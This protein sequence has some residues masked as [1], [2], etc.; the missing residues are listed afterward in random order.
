MSF[1]VG[2]VEPI[3][4]KNHDPTA[5]DSVLEALR[6]TSKG[7]LPYPEP[8][9]GSSS[10]DEV[11]DSKYIGDLSH[12][13]L[14]QNFSNEV[15]FSENYNN[16]ETSIFAN[17]GTDHMRDLQKQ[18]KLNHNFET[19]DFESV[20]FDELDS[21]CDYSQECIDTFRVSKW[22]SYRSP[23]KSPT[24][25]Y[26]EADDPYTTTAVADDDDG[27]DAAVATNTVDV[28]PYRDM[29]LLLAHMQIDMSVST[30]LARIQQ[31]QAAYVARVA[32]I[33]AHTV[34]E[35]KSC[36]EASNKQVEEQ[37]INQQL[38]DNKV[39]SVIAH[40][41][42]T[43]VVSK[44]QEA[45][46][47]KNNL[48]SELC[49]QQQQ[50]EEQQQQ[51]Q[52][53]ELLQQQQDQLKQT[54]HQ[55]LLN[56][57]K[58][59]Y[60]QFSAA[61]DQ[62]LREVGECDGLELR[63][64]TSSSLNETLQLSTEVLRSAEHQQQP[65]LIQDTTNRLHQG[66]TVLNY[67]K[68]IIDT[69]KTQVD[70]SS[71][72]TTAANSTESA[73]TETGSV[74]LSLAR[75]NPSTDASLAEALE[76]F[77]K[78]SEIHKSVSDISQ[79]LASQNNEMRTQLSRA[80]SIVNQFNNDSDASNRQKLH[81]LINLVSGQ[82]CEAG[83]V[84]VSTGADKQSP[85]AMFVRE[86]L[87]SKLIALAHDKQVNSQAVYSSLM[88]RLWQVDP[89]IQHLCLYHLYKTCPYLVPCLPFREDYGSEEEYHRAL[90]YR[91][92]DGEK[93]EPLDSYI[94]RMGSAAQLYGRL[95]SVQMP[96]SPLGEQ[97]SWNL[98][99]RLLVLPVQSAVT[100]S[101]LHGFFS[102][103][104]AMMG[105]TYG[106]QFRKLMVLIQEK[107]LPL[108]QEVTKE[109]GE[110]DLASIKTLLENYCQT[111]TVPP[112]IEGYRALL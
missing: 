79:K 61:L 82:L 112:P 65:Q 17:E 43:L 102:T 32:D 6:G 76:N 47:R 19:K 100:C 75:D 50:E 59:S 90:G 2:V 20:R 51:R 95:V 25:N 49:Q 16:I 30:V 70:L 14:S 9:L 10:S 57:L 34:A 45:A 40:H 94:K 31:Y 96:N 66:I 41:T 110:A 62:V 103:A 54:E 37:R 12:I 67:V 101:V 109:G 48:L 23:I 8:L 46:D 33:H 35:L 18:F 5:L 24:L 97:H 3:H 53:A 104:G 1:A 68:G 74:P 28:K 91:H 84:Q 89:L 73:T 64:E 72:T 58:E 111:G 77:K 88:L 4:Y 81:Q 22:S 11:C 39:H 27:D 21:K 83:G 108:L 71:S 52:A 99:S 36:I 13:T 86:Q 38:L 98:L 60:S 15:S 107:F 80:M 87:S 78:L 93:R 29:E 44:A 92:K 63:P 69:K 42:D 85:A 55:G 105:K 26:G 7:R 106:Q 56:G